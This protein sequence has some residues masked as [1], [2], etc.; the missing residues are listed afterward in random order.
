MFI[1]QEWGIGAF[2]LMVKSLQTYLCVDGNW[3]ESMQSSIGEELNMITSVMQIEQFLV[4]SA[5]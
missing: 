3:V 2:F 1:Y 5:T 4:K